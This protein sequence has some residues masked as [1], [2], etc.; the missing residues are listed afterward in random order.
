METVN[1]KS[2][3]VA[4][5][6]R[7]N[8]GKSTLINNILGSKIVITSEKAQTTRNRINCIYN[9]DN[10]QIVFIDIPGFLKPKNLLTE[11]LNKLI[12]KTINDADI[13]LAVVDVSTGIGKGDFFIFEKLKEINKPVVLL[14]NKI[15]L[16]SKR[17]IEIEI[18]KVKEFDFFK[19]ILL[20]SALEDK[21][22]NQLLSTV[23]KYLP[24]GMAFYPDDILSDR[25]VRSIAEDIIREKLITKL[26]DEL[27][28]SVTVEI[29]KFEEGMTK[30]KD[31]IVRINAIIF[32]QRTAHKS[33]IIGKNGS[34]LKEIGTL[35]RL[36]LE[37]FLDSKVHIELWVKVRE[38]WTKDEAALKEFG[39]DF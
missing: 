30:S 8:V 13:V 9:D 5:A 37:E 1:F 24:V 29:D 33:M 4:L 27:P 18:D 32:T 25:P 39:Y 6:G 26:E 36:E 23:K 11:K 22:F 16:S 35:A 2:G 31:K 15:D 3:F 38:D 12:A 10:S 7:T 28:H 14:L 20:I 21:N 34:L 17:N 19:D